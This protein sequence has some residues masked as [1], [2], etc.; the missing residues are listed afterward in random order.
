SVV[1]T[2]P[3]LG[4]LVLSA[5][6]ARG[7]PRRGLADRLQHFSGRDPSFWNSRRALHTQQLMKPEV[8]G[9]YGV[10]ILDDHLRPLAPHKHDVEVKGEVD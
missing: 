4:I 1:T 5:C 8:G 3:N 10:V 2:S 6:L 9:A 7:W